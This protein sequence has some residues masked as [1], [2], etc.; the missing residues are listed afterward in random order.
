MIDHQ[1][2]VRQQ[3]RR[4]DRGCVG[5]GGVDGHELDLLPKLRGPLG[6]PG[7]DRGTGTAFALPE[8]ALHASQV[9]EPGVPWVDPHPSTRPGAGTV[10]L[11]QPNWPM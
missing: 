11:S 7:D 2:G 8:Q 5:G 3:P 6:Q 10:N 9:D 1:R 4:A